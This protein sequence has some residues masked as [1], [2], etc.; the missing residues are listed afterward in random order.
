MTKYTGDV[1]LNIG[2]KKHTLCFDWR[3]IA[4]VQEEVATT[5]MVN[6]FQASP[7]VL[8]KILSIGLYKHHGDVSE[9]SILDASP[10]IAEVVSAI[11]K[12][13]AYSYYGADG[14]PKV[15]GEPQKKT[16]TK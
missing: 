7:K 3:A 15:A 12:A 5:E 4:R 9:D 11:D 2:G 13:V 1:A 10:V 6:L 16:V 14:A 8:A